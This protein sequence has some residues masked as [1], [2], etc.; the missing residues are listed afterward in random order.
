MKVSVRARNTLPSPTLGITARAKALAA[1]G[2]DVIDFGA[3][4]PDFD[5][6]AHIRA[7]AIEAIE[8]GF[9]RYTPSAGAPA[10]R[11]AVCQSFLR[12]YGLQ[13]RPEQ[14]LVGVGAKHVLFNLM[15]ALLDPGDEVII[16]SPY[17]VSYPE[18]V[19][20]AG[21]VPVALCGEPEAG[22]MPSTDGVKAA[23]TPRTRAIILNSPGNPTGA[24]ASRRRVK[25]LVSLAIKHDLVIISDEIYAK[26]IYDDNEHVSPAGLGAEAYARTVTVN[27]CSKTWA[28]TGWRIGYCGAADTELIS[29]MSRMQDQS[30]SNPASISQ[31]AALAALTG[32]QECVEEMRLAFEERRNRIVELLNAIPGIRCPMPGGAFYAF[33]DVSGLIGLGAD[34]VTIDGADSLAAYLLDAVQVAVVPGA[35]FGAPGNIRISYA[36]SIPVIEAGLERMQDAICR[37]R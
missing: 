5:T 19:K 21:G 12:D 37:L 6:P 2:V 23:L 16:P 17:W 15:Q 26:L 3:G 18:Q 10:L 30:T 4:E 13:Y 25:E 22:Y 29:A 7:A 35:G 33:P 8:Q 34:N 1:Q 24:V 20:L 9:T 31:K 11:Q 28:M 27:G 14:V 36:T 32:P